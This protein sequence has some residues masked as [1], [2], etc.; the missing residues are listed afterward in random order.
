MLEHQIHI[1]EPLV[2][3]QIA[4]GEVIE[5]PASI[6]KECIENSIDAKATHIIVEVERAGFDSITIT[7]D[8][9]GIEEHDLTR[10]ILRHATS[11]LRTSDDLANIQHLGFRGEA[12][13]SIA[14]VSL[15]T[16]RSKVKDKDAFECVSHPLEG[17]SVHPCQGERGTRIHIQELFFNVPARRRFLKSPKTEMGHI[18]QVFLRLALGHPERSFTLIHNGQT[19]KKL[20]AGDSKTRIEQIAGRSFMQHANT[21]DEVITGC[22]IEGWVAP[23][24]Y[25]SRQNDCQYFY[26]NGRAIRDKLILQAIRNAYTSQYDLMPG[27][28]PCYA[29]FLQVPFDE[30]DVNVHPTKHEVRFAEP[31]LIYDF[32]TTAIAKALDEEQ[33]ETVAVSQRDNVQPLTRSKVPQ[34]SLPPTMDCF[35]PKVSIDSQFAQAQSHLFV[36][37][38]EKISIIPKEGTRQDLLKLY[39]AN[40]D[41][42]IAQQTL[43]FPKSLP[44]SVTESQCVRLREFGFD[45]Q[46]REEGPMLLRQPKVFCPQGDSFW[47]KLGSNQEILADILANFCHFDCFLLPQVELKQLAIR[48]VQLQAAGCIEVAR[49]QESVSE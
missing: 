23:A 3:N 27:T 13:S 22:C 18:E 32:V 6:I 1:L 9:L 46:W 20:R 25:L 11:K 2:A 48:Y 21:V 10:A 29:L 39:Y 40:K 12:L 15:L 19:I 14:A 49:E 31:R 45:I 42:S 38:P 16:I 4:A 17:A 35:L 7:D 33:T 41:A 47:Q 43:M 36:I 34:R 8:G 28:Y 26:V 24:A 44:T 37:L 30:V 5:R